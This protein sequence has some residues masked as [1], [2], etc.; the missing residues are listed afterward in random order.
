MRIDNDT[1]RH[2]MQMLI[3]ENHRLV[4]DNRKLITAADNADRET[5]LHEQT[6]S[7]MT[8]ALMGARTVIERAVQGK[9]L[10]ASGAFIIEKINEALQ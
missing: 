6:I 3:D 5:E 10:G 1:A 8:D 4:A 2:I 9:D 7:S